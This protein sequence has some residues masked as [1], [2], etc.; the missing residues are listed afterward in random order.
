M[1][2]E[3]RA[4]SLGNVII[5][6]EVEISVVSEF[7]GT[8]LEA[9]EQVHDSLEDLVATSGYQNMSIDERA[10]AVEEQLQIH[11]ANGLVDDNSIKYDTRNQM[12][13]FTHTSGVL[14]GIMLAPFNSDLNGSAP[15]TRAEREAAA[16]AKKQ[17][18]QQ[19]SFALMRMMPANAYEN[20][21]I[22][23]AMIFYRKD[24]ILNPGDVKIKV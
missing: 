5:T 14:G 24:V 2:H 7:A 13:T 18:P 9:M 8:D 19:R 22:G 15:M 10:E 17:Q 1:L 21:E 4:Y 11:V 12:Y 23:D 16:L 20:M 3:N 6:N